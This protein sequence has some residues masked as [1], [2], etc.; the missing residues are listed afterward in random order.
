MFDPVGDCFLEFGH[1]AER[2]SPNPL[3]CQLCEKPFDQVQPGRA[4][5]GE[6]NMEAWVSLE[7]PP[8]LKMFV[9]GVVVDDQMK[10]EFGRHLLMQQS[11]KFQPLLMAMSG[12]ALANH[13]SAEHL[14]GSEKGCGAMASIVMRPAC[15]SSSL[16]R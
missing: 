14:N 13:L 4:R 10:I 7:P 8:H 12:H 16:E 11:K 9:C 3:G 6:V 5:R 15:G 2:A 1:A